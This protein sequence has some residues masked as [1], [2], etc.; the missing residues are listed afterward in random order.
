[1]YPKRYSLTSWRMMGRGWHKISG[2][3]GEMGFEEIEQYNWI[4]HFRFA[5][6]GLRFSISDLDDW[7]DNSFPP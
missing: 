4:I 6:E 3:A 2:A 1:M 7:M 5:P